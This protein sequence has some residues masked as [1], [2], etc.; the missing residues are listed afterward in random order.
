[1]IDKKNRFWVTEII[2]TEKMENC[3]PV[4]NMPSYPRVLVPNYEDVWKDGDKDPVIRKA[5]TKSISFTVQ[6]FTPSLRHLPRYILD[7]RL[8]RRRVSL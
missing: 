5:G 4:C 6:P 1:M 2:D 8:G 3:S 7:R